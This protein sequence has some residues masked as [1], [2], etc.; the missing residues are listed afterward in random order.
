MKI[1]SSVTQLTVQ[2]VGKSLIKKAICINFSV[3]LQSRS[4]AGGRSLWNRTRSNDL[5]QNSSYAPKGRV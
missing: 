4:L 3:L 2:N 1:Y 5:W